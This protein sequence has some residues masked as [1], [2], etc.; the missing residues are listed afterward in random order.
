[1]LVAHESSVLDLFSVDLDLLAAVVVEHGG[2]QSHA[3]ILARSLGV[4][5]V[6]QVPDLMSRVR[7]GQLLFVDGATGLIDLDP[8]PKVVAAQPAARACAMRA[9]APT[10]AEELARPDLPHVEA[11]INLLCEVEQAVEGAPAP[12]ACTAPSSYSSP[13]GPSRPRKSKSAST[14]SC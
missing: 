9:P 7:P 3:A 14:A 2:P 10:P 13:D 1:M 6:G 12:S 11:N 8:S 4:P 5:M